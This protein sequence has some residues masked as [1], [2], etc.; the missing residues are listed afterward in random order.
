MELK[1]KTLFVG[2]EGPGVYIGPW[3]LSED[4]QQSEDS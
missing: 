4:I 1:V 3:T 2:M